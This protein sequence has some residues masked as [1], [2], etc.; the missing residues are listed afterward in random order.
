[1]WP[2][3]KLPREPDVDPSPS[4]EQLLEAIAAVSDQLGKFIRWSYRIQKSQADTLAKLETLVSDASAARGQ[5]QTAAEASLGYTVR[6]MM[7]WLDDLD[8]LSDSRGQGLVV[9]S[10]LL[11]RWSRQLLD[12]LED[13]GYQELAV[14][15]KPF[16]SRFC[17]ALGTT[18]IWEGEN[19]PQSYAV[20][21]VLRRGFRHKD[22]LFRK[23]QVIVYNG[24]QEFS[25]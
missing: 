20:V 3:K 14:E 13:L 16:D 4:P 24:T 12:R 5:A 23:A 1:M 11:R 9:D 21:S 2:F 10:A 17:E 6:G 8:T 15:G 25:S 18:A 19:P 7:E 22:G